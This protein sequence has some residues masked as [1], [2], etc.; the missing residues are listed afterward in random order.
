MESFVEPSIHSGGSKLRAVGIHQVGSGTS[1]R[2]A[3]PCWLEV[4][5]IVGKKT[6][7]VLDFSS[8]ATSWHRQVCPHFGASRKEGRNNLNPLPRS[9]RKRSTFCRWESFTPRIALSD[10]YVIIPRSES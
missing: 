4:E 3:K 9:N 5:R 7:N 2:R 1:R 10:D 8:R 6:F